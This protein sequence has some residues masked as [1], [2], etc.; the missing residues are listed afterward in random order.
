MK[1]IFCKFQDHLNS[2]QEIRD[3]ITLLLKYNIILFLI[4]VFNF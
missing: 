1:E 3:V 4:F 2:E